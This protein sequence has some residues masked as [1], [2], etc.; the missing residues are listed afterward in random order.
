MVR[1]KEHVLMVSFV[2]PMENVV[3]QPITITRILLVMEVMLEHT[4]VWQKPND[5]VM[6]TRVV[7]AS[8]TLPHIINGISIAEMLFIL[9]QET[10]PGLLSSKRNPSS[11]MFFIMMRIALLLSVQN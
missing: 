1:P 9:M 11:E 2:T 6:T 3:V 7:N 5:N 4:T 10:K 8:I